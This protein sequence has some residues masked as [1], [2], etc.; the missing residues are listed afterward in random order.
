MVKPRWPSRRRPHHWR[1][2]QASLR[3]AMQHRLL[4]PLRWLPR[5]LQHRSPR[6]HRLPLPRQPPQR[7]SYLRQ[8]SLLPRRLRSPRLHPLQHRLPAVPRCVSSS[9]PIAGRRSPMATA[10]CCSMPPSARVTP[11]NSAASHRSRSAWAMP[12]ARRS[13]TTASPSMW[14]RSSVARLLA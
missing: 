1:S 12:V 3:P 13:V 4:K 11:W 9:W 2:N 14:R 10:R 6:L 8:P 7:W 5:R